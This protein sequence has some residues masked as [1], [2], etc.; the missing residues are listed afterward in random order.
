MQL[1]VL[2]TALTEGML[3]LQYFLRRGHIR[4]TNAKEQVK[5]F[6]LQPTNFGLEEAPQKEHQQKFQ[7]N[8]KIIRLINIQR[9]H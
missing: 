1:Q 3:Q 9:H 6:L 4:V 2:I 7:Y 5:H 8:S